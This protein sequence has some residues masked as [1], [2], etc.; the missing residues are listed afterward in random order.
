M[1]EAILS[2]ETITSLS[3]TEAARAPHAV[4]LQAELPQQGV[5]KHWFPVSRREVQ[6]IEA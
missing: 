2:L 1:E 3:F 5:R 4:L 6:I